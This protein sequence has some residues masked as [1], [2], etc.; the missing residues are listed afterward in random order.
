MC[1]I[2]IN[3]NHYSYQSHCKGKRSYQHTVGFCTLLS[4][5]V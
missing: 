4:V 5:F 3:V 1:D 2:F